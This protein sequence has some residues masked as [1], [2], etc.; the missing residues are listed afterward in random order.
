MTR[1]VHGFAVVI[2]AVVFVQIVVRPG[3]RLA[4]ALVVWKMPVVAPV[5][6]LAAV[7]QTATQTVFGS[8]G[9]TTILAMAVRRNVAWPV[10][11]HFWPPFWETRIPSPQKLSPLLFV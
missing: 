10:S 3:G 11:A 6:P 4:R 1:S 2:A 9:S 7:L 5:L 8:W